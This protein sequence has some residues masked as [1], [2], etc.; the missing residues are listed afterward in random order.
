MA[1][2]LPDYHHRLR[3][4]VGGPAGKRPVAGG[5]RTSGSARIE[6]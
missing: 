6:T 5:G 3:L 1:G 2:C 4:S